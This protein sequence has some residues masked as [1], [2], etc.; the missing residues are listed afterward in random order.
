M[1]RTSLHNPTKMPGWLPT[2]GIGLLLML[3]TLQSAAI[4]IAFPLSTRKFSGGERFYAT[5]YGSGDTKR[6]R[7]TI[8][9]NLKNGSKTVFSNEKNAQ[10]YPYY[11]ISTD[12]I[13]IGCDVSSIVVWAQEYN[14]HIHPFR[15]DRGYEASITGTWNIEPLYP[16][17]NLKTEEIAA[18]SSAPYTAVRLNSQNGLPNNYTQQWYHTK[19]NAILEFSPIFTS[20]SASEKFTPSTLE[21]QTVY[22]RAV[23]TRNGCKAVSEITEVNYTRLKGG[24]SPGALNFPDT[25]CYGDALELTNE[26]LTANPNRPEFTKRWE[27]VGNHHITND[28]GKQNIFFDGLGNK[29]ISLFLNNATPKVSGCE[30][31]TVKPIYVKDCFADAI[32]CP[33]TFAPQLGNYFFQG[34][35]GFDGAPPQDEIPSYQLQVNYQNQ[36]VK[37]FTFTPDLSKG[38]DGWYPV[39]GTF[40]I[41]ERAL[42]LKVNMVNASNSPAYFDDV[43][44]QPF[45]S[46]LKGYVFDNQTKRM[47]AELDENNYATFYEYDEEGNLIRIKKETERGVMTIQESNQNRV[48]K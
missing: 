8:T 22:V 34:W 31:K 44:I 19:L 6:I 18:C 32:C 25:I 26:F 47:T 27:F 45:N 36:V 33:S 43:R 42:A 23:I 48:K 1:K 4:Q 15:I 7:Y 11:G 21:T 5:I 37:T 35:I 24:T 12:L 20:K 46:S 30:F 29:S 3:T 17:S 41:S 40:N 39:T 10:G 9:L 2:L 14:V 16:P 13:D 38:I 28:N